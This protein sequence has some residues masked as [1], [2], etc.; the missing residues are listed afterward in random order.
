M[1]PINGRNFVGRQGPLVFCAKRDY[2]DAR[3]RSGRH[4]VNRA[5]TANANCFNAK[6]MKTLSEI[7]SN[8][9]VQTEFAVCAF[10]CGPSCRASAHALCCCCARCRDMH[11]I[12][13]LSTMSGPYHA[14]GR[15]SVRQP[16]LASAGHARLQRN[17]RPGTWLPDSALVW[18]LS[19]FVRAMAQMCVTCAAL[20]PSFEVWTAVATCLQ[21][22]NRIYCRKAPRI[23]TAFEQH[24]R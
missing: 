4:G 9:G 16:R 8:G 1:F 13:S 12:V 22:Q 21:V 17:V 23:R 2:R 7:G 5:R 6:T 18:T 15:L 14:R 20:L 3:S 10:C 11:Q 24:P 19:S